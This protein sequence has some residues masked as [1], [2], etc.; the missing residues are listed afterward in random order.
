MVLFSINEYQKD[1]VDPIL[2]KHC[3]YKT[4]WHMNPNSGNLI[5]VYTM[6]LNKK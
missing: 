6:V 5:K 2:D 4:D 1:T 3:E